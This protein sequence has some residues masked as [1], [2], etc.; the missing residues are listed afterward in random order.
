M[1]LKH[2]YKYM[3][4]AETLGTD[5]NPCY[6]RQIGVV[7]VKETPNSSRIVG[8]GYNGPAPGTPHTDEHDYLV[9]FLWPKLTPGDKESLRLELGISSTTLESTRGSLTTLETSLD[10]VVRDAFANKYA[11]CKTCP[12]RLVGAKSG[13]RNDL[14]TCGHAE[15]HAIT[16]AA[17]DLSGCSMFI[18]TDVGPCVQCAD[19]IVQAGITHVYWW[20]GQPYE[21]GAM[22]LMDR[23]KVTYQE[24]DK[25]E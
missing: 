23:G 21:K 2:I 10:D 11:G 17:C 22:W 4:L 6:S 14:C 5:T 12:R 13:E 25:I 15:R 1:K 9:N 8:T 16:N 20:K 18:G 19:S 7:I 24:L 3:R